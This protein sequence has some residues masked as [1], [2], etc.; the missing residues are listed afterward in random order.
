MTGLS[1]VPGAHVPAALAAS[2]IY[3]SGPSYF[4][5]IFG[6]QAAALAFMEGAYPHWT[7][8]WG[9]AHH[10][11]LRDG[12]QVLGLGAFY[13]GGV[14]WQRLLGSGWAMLTQ[15]IAQRVTTLWRSMAMTRLMPPPCRGTLMIEHIAICPHA[16]GRGLGRWMLTQQLDAAKRRGL[17]EAALYVSEENPG[18]ERLY[19]R[20]GFTT[21]ET[22][23]SVGVPAVKTMRLKL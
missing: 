10:V 19:T 9:H 1:L 3:A 20:L 22:R 23:T 21:Q 5:F 11:A 14:V 6:G 7:G 15:P 2:L 18:A 13:G 4:D 16:R 17:R 8:F 12:N